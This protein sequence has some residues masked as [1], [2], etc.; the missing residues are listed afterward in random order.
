MT[1]PL[2]ASASQRYG[3]NE[4]LTDDPMTQPSP[5]HRPDGFEDQRLCVVPRPQVELALTRPGTRLLTVTDAGYFPAASGHHRSR[6]EG[7]AE[8]VVILCVAGSG[9]VRIRNHVF[10]VAPGACVIIPANTPHEYQASAGAPWTIWWMHI[11]GTEVAELTGPLLETPRPVTHLRAV[12]GV[13]ALFDELI[14]LLE[15]IMS[16]QQLLTATGVAWQLLTHL[17]ADSVLP[18]DGS[19]LERAMR[20]LE[21]RVSGNIKASEL[22]GMVLVSPSHLNALF[23][24]ATGGGPGAFHTSLKMARARHLLDTS[25]LSIAEIASSVGYKDPLYFSRH[26]RRVHGVNPTQYRQEHK[27]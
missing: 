4:R 27:G 14:T 8:T 21:T 19:P 22:A 3:E 6:D 12:E 13:V 25:P 23:R 15:R 9:R 16:P 2:D 7:I 24:R 20:F 5:H 1:R 10:A 17:A 18:A 11:R 26:F